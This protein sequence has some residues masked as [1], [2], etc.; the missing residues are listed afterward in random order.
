MKLK[1]GIE[2][3]LKEKNQGVELF[4]RNIAHGGKIP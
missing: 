1:A 3:E 4:V 2:V